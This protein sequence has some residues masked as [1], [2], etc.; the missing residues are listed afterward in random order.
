MPIWALC[1][2]LLP[3]LRLS[4]PLSEAEGPM[5][6]LITAVPSLL[7]LLLQ[8][9][10]MAPPPAAPLRSRPSPISCA[11][12][13]PLTSPRSSRGCGPAFWRAHFTASSSPTCT[14]LLLLSRA[15]SARSPLLLLL[16]MLP[17]MM[18]RTMLQVLLPLRPTTAITIRCGSV[19]SS[20]ASRKASSHQRAA[21]RTSRPSAPPST[22]QRHQQMLPRSN[23]S[24]R[25]STWFERSIRTCSV[26]V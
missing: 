14:V 11:S 8:R 19:S 26:R 5:P 25:S 6:L 15:A 17:A 21:R 10:R 20:R 22:Q 3:L 9:R 12:S 7:L 16:R 4:R 24:L 1:R 23:S 13:P 18:M 2:L